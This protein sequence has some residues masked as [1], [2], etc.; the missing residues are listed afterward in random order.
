MAAVNDYL[1]DFN[2]VSVLFRLVLALV[3][4]ALTGYGR[5]RKKQNAGLRTYMLVSVGAALTILISMYEYEMLTS[6]WSFAAEVAEMKF[7]GTR[8]AAQ[9]INGV[10]FLAAGNIIAISH[11][12]VA[13]LTTAIGLFASAC[14]GIAAGAGFY[15]CVIL[16]IVVIVIAMEV[17]QPIE[18]GYKRRIR[19]ITIYVE[20]ESAEDIGTITEAIKAQNAQ[21]FE[22]ELERSEKVGD[23]YPAAIISLKM[24]KNNASHS[25]LLSSVA[26][27]SC[28]SS[29]Q[30]IE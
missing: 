8:I 5:A 25:A 19:N 1:R 6:N 12:R 23:K 28:V 14:L 27:L 26:E 13:G 16:S 11:Q 22:L 7:D 20:F 10:G 30:E 21:I 18:T 17:F 2:F 24:A 9:V 3:S 29:I 4:G 15:E